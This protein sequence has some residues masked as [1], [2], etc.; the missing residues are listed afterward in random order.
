MGASE[1]E[2]LA[3]LVHGLNPRAVGSEK[4]R[5]RHGP[6]PQT[7][8]SRVEG[9]S[10]SELVSAKRRPKPMALDANDFRVVRRFNLKVSKSSLLA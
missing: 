10:M 6:E 4:V 1:S 8:Q 5:D 7:V 2:P 9:H 3:K